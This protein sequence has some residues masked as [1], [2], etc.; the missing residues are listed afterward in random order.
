MRNPRKRCVCCKRLVSI[1]KVKV[2][3]HRPV[4]FKDKRF[5]TEAYRHIEQCQLAEY[6]EINQRTVD[7]QRTMQTV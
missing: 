4:D 7:P 6:R 5:D 2:A 3:Y 1:K